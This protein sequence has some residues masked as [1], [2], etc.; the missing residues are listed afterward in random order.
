ML[1]FVVSKVGDAII[2]TDLS[3]TVIGWNPAARDVYGRA[4][5]SVLGLHVSKAV[6]APLDAADVVERGGVTRATHFAYGGTPLPMRVAVSPTP[7]GYLVICVEETARQRDD[8]HFRAVLNLLDEGVVVFSNDGN[9]QTANRA[10]ARIWGPQFSQDP[11]T[12]GNGMDL[13]E[14]FDTTGRPLDRHEQPMLRTFLTG[15]VVVGS[16]VGFDRP[17]G[18]RVWLSMSCRRLDS[19]NRRGA[20]VLSFTDITAQKTATALLAYRASHDALTALPNRAHALE[21]ITDALQPGASQ[22]AAVLYVDLDNLKNIND[23]HGH[24]V[25]DAVLQTGARRLRATARTGDV[26]A[27]L[28]GD[29]FVTLLISPA[30]AA[31]ID[32]LASRLLQALSAPIQV[33]GLS[34]TAGASIGI[35]TVIQGDARDA[36]QILHDADQAMYEAK[37]K[38]RN[39]IQYFI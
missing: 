6:A 10:A 8:D 24:E 39:R 18:E 11:G 28:G 25:G 2:E 31:D 27:R 23:S 34:L 16:V 9:V 36:A 35:T 5:Q 15:E 19:D 21:C 7:G 4:A 32:G 1:E 29:E 3:G 38:G 26:V 30:A 17:T 22:L 33:E 14:L 12:F 13:L 37:R 20:I